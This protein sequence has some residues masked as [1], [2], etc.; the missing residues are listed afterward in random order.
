MSA[1]IPSTRRYLAKQA[2]KEALINLRPDDDGYLEV[3]EYENDKLNSVIDYV[4]DAV[5]EE[6]RGWLRAEGVIV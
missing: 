5:H 6:I 2:L 1:I 4:C 3:N